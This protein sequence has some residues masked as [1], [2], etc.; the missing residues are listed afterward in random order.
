MSSNLLNKL[1]VINND[2]LRLKEILEDKGLTPVDNGLTTLV[3]EVNEL[4]KAS[5]ITDNIWTGISAEDLAEPENYFVP[6]FNMDAV[7]EAD[8]TKDSY[9]N[10]MLIL[11]DADETKQNLVAGAITGFTNF[12]FSDAPSTVVTSTAHTWDESQDLTGTDGKKY[13]W[14]MCYTNSSSQ[15][16]VWSP[17]I[18]TPYAFVVYKGSYGVFNIRYNRVGPHYVETKSGTTFTIYHNNGGTYS[19]DLNTHLQTFISNATRIQYMGTGLFAGCEALRYVKC[20]S[21][22]TT[23]TAI[24]RLFVN[25]RNCWIYLNNV[26]YSTNSGNNTA[27]GIFT[28]MTECVVIVP[29]INRLAGAYHWRQ[30]SW[31]GWSKQVCEF[32]NVNNCKFKIDTITGA[33]DDKLSDYYGTNRDCEFE[34]GEVG[35]GIGDYYFSHDYGMPDCKVKIGRIGGKIG[36]SA[37]QRS[38]FYGDVVMFNGDNTDIAIGSNAFYATNITSLDCG[39]ARVTSVG[40]QAFYKCPLFNFFQMNGFATSMGDNVFYGCVQLKTLTMGKSVATI[41]AA[42]FANS[43]IEHLVCGDAL[44]TIPASAFANLPLRH[45]TLSEYVATINANAFQNTKELEDITIPETV[46]TL[47]ADCFNGSG[48]KR[49]IGAEGV[50]N[51]GN[52]AFYNCYRLE[53]LQL[54]E[55]TTFGTNVFYDCIKLL[56]FV[57]TS[58]LISYTASTFQNGPRILFENG[59]ALSVDLNLSY[60]HLTV[61]NVLDLI[62]ALPT[63]EN[64]VVLVLSPTAHNT[65]TNTSTNFWS[66]IRNKYVKLNETEDGLKYCDSTDEG[67]VLVSTY[68]ANKNYSVS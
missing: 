13:R 34:I 31:D 39:N 50:T 38:N 53:S 12:K 4:H 61:D 28:D 37:F 22:W 9:S 64:A 59:V 5:V 62:Y 7:Y 55:A 45:I 18:I 16:I 3:E 35:L 42:T 57:V 23:N 20:T 11:I 32:Q 17:T 30:Y 27:S 54:P 6:G 15:N 14:I 51:I 24:T 48:V 33:I 47:P 10:V 68:L 19:A 60:A 66:S 2:R 25:V 46:K 41:T 26:L 52:N 67:A 21:E 63:N 36:V 49:I 65:S 56:D 1:R 29:T 43:H 8:E 58:N 40:S 44:V